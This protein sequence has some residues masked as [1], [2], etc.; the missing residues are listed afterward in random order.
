MSSIAPS[1]AQASP[2]VERL[3]PI[4]PSDAQASDSEF[5]TKT[6]KRKIQ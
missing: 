3:S 1:D 5:L 6:N 2:M 4:V